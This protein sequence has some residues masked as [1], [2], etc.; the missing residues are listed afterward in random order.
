MIFKS[1]QVISSNSRIHFLDQGTHSTTQAN[2]NGIS[3]IKK[4]LKNRIC[5]QINNKEN[6]ENLLIFIT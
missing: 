5:K 6:K 2:N 4:E 3:R 1:V